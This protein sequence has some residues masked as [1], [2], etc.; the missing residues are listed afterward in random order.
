MAKAKK[1]RIAANLDNEYQEGEFSSNGE[2]EN[3]NN[4]SANY[5]YSDEEV[6][7]EELE[8][9]QMIATQIEACY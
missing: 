4:T 1:N 2:F 6:S 7:A 9:L 3:Q 8:E 5:Q